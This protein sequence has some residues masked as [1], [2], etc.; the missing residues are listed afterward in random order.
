MRGNAVLFTAMNEAVVDAVDLPNPGPSDVVVHVVYSGIS[1]GTE[2][3]ILTNQ[4]K[5]VTYPLIPGYQA[6]G[7]VADVGSDVSR[8]RVGDRVLVLGTRVA[9]GGPR[10][11]WGGHA[12]TV[13]CAESTLLPVPDNVPLMH[14]A[15]TVL[16]AV[17]HHGLDVCG[18]CGP[19]DLVV[20]TGLGL[21][22]LSAVQ[23]AR[24]YG[25]DVIATDIMQ[26]RVELAG[27]LGAV[28]AL[29][30]D[31][32]K[33]AA[34][35]KARK[36]D[37]ADLVIDTSAAEKAI[38]FGFELLRRQGRYCFQG[39]YPGLTSIDFWWPH[40]KELLF[41]NPT[42]FRVEGKSAV[43]SSMATGEIDMS[44]LVKPVFKVHDVSEAYRQVWEEPSA[45]LAGVI[46]WREE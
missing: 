1:S 5:G 42:S 43:L 8:W 16:P 3:W 29:T 14:A 27:R 38:N 20:V 22:G 19:G 15:Q 18:R 9:E 13:V 41:Y 44:L 40:V 46:Q 39:Y 4:Y 7:W 30:F 24:G 10:T 25:A 34:A 32:E 6:T 23:I 2:R 17:A 28:E 12:D 21:V 26:D 37:G 31:E 45:F 36:P 11:M 33:L 35:V